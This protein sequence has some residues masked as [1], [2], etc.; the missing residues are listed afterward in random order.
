ME[1]S[2]AVVNRQI[3]SNAKIL[4]IIYCAL[5]LEENNESI[6]SA[7]S[8]SWLGLLVL[9]GFGCLSAGNLDNWPAKATCQAGRDQKTFYLSIFLLLCF[10]IL[11]WFSGNSLN[12][13]DKLAQWFTVM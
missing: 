8:L 12:N 5:H 3:N 9:H 4:F 6:A 7:Y 10:S 11:S 1:L 13:K 2:K